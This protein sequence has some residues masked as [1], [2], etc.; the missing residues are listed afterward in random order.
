MEGLDERAK[1][2]KERKEARHDAEDGDDRDER[3]RGV[4]ERGE[5]GKGAEKMAL[6]SENRG[7][8][9]RQK[10]GC[11]QTDRSEK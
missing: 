8:T 2:K 3:L 4:E 1:K 10:A 7:A 11:S 5:D 6:V 9:R